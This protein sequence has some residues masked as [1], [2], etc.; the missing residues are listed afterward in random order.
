[1]SATSKQISAGEGEGNGAR[2]SPP[3]S[4]LFSG[5]G[6]CSLVQPNPGCALL[7]SRIH[8]V[9]VSVDVLLPRPIHGVFSSLSSF[10]DI[11]GTLSRYG[12]S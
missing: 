12:A 7:Q 6:Y 4:R 1:M 9:E 11:R 5:S 2:L 10:Q 3:G 8:A